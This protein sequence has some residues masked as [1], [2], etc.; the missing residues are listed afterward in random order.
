MQAEFDFQN[1][2]PVKLNHLR[3]LTDSTGMLQ[4]ATH[5]IANYKSGYTTDDNARALVAVLKYHALFNSM[6]SETLAMICLGFL[7][8]VQQPDGT[9]HNNVSFER[10]FLEEETGW[11]CFG[12]V[13]W[14]CGY[15][16]YSKLYENAKAT[17]KK[18]FDEAMPNLGKL[19][20]CRPIA[21]AIIGLHYYHSAKPEQVDL[22]EKIIFLGE[23]L[24]LMLERNS[25]A[26]WHWFEQELTY[27][28]ARIPHA[29]FLAYQST[30]DSRF[31]EAAER[32]F[33]FLESK[34]IE[35]G[36]F[37]PVGQR[38][39]FPKGGPKAIFDQ[40]PIEASAM[41]DAAVEAFKVTGKENYKRTAVVSF[42]WFLGRN[43]LQARVYDDV[44]GACFDGLTE[45]EPNKNQGA[46]STI[47]YLLARLAIEEIARMSQTSLNH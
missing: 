28:N 26:D 27:C 30:K 35:S 22:K 29:L 34:T 32:S 7:H 25:G 11:D 5:S 21:F 45:T 20:D 17:A 10:K 2:P 16:V 12:R 8:Y 9:F 4:H 41:V 14:A 40:Q 24:L 33:A 13:L 19:E 47:A 3:L 15:A 42:E 1:L 23:K 37:V 44:N 36:M 38:G 6:D 39:W 31:L 18:M 43:S 46:E